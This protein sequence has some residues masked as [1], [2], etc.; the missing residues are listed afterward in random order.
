[1]K[2][3]NPGKGTGMGSAFHQNEKKMMRRIERKIK[4]KEYEP[5][6]VTR[7]DIE[8]D[9]TPQT[10]MKKRSVYKKADWATAKKAA[11]A[12]G[13]DLS[14]LAKKRNALRDAGDTSSD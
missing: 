12:K 2:G 11:T 1:M 10:T 13:W 14:D 6:T 5:Q 8:T 9:I 4:K 7:K 3:F